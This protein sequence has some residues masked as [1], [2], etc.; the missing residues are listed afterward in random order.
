VESP[1][2][3]DGFLGKPLRTGYQ[4]HYVRTRRDGKP[5]KDASDDV[6]S[7]DEIV[8]AQESQILPF[9]IIQFDKKKLEMLLKVYARDVGDLEDEDKFKLMVKPSLD[10]E[11]EANLER[12]LQ[13][14]MIIRNPRDARRPSVAVRVVI[15]QESD[16]DKP[17]LS[18]NTT[19]TSSEELGLTT[20]EVRSVVVDLKPVDAL[21][22]KSSSGSRHSEKDSSLSM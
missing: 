13:A 6:E 15:P 1:A 20:G 10:V 17:H 11:E 16:K 21:H 18:P 9:A 12:V 22:E 8:I 4:S 19:S 3:Q 7:F 5:V 14:D 2:D